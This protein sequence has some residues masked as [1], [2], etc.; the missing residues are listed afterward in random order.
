MGGLRELGPVPPFSCPKG[1]SSKG[2]RAQGQWACFRLGSSGQV[3]NKRFKRGSLRQGMEE[4]RVFHAAR[5]PSESQA[6]ACRTKSTGASLT[7]SGS[8]A[9]PGGGLEVTGQ[10]RAGEGAAGRRR[11]PLSM[12]P[13]PGLPFLLQDSLWQQEISNLSEWLSPGPEP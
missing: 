9:S 3:E 13:H 12:G 8:R 2:P 11:G 10:G 7:P 5:V 1:L 4:T 6:A